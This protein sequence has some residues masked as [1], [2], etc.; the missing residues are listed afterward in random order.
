MS[1]QGTKVIIVGGSSGLGLAT[2]YGIVQQHGGGVTVEN[3]GGRVEVTRPGWGTFIKDANT[4][5]TKPE[6]WP[7]WM[8]DT[9]K[10][11]MAFK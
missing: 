8:N 10:D 7:K 4:K 1:L 11:S 5:P 6:F 2:V 9:V 3:A